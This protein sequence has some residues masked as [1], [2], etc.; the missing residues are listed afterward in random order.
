MSEMDTGF[1]FLPSGS[2]LGVPQDRSSQL[3]S[4]SDFVSKFHWLSRPNAECR[5]P[6]ALSFLALE[7]KILHRGN[8]QRL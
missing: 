8:P 4:A 2:E 6:N 3:W 5:P 7:H 1:I